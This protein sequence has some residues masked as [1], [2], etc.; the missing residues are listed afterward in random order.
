MKLSNGICK[1]CGVEKETLCHLLC[2]CSKIE[3]IWSLIRNFLYKICKVD[4]FINVDEILF[5]VD[6]SNRPIENVA[7][8]III[9]TKWQIWKNRNNVKYNQ[10]CLSAENIF[11]NV[12]TG[13]KSKAFHVIHQLNK[14]E[15]K[16]AVKDTKKLFQNML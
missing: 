13:C 5:G 12:K 1:L 6:L 9:E 11:N 7:N 10:E 4:L 8:F 16:Q 14:K 2:E 3:I 15:D